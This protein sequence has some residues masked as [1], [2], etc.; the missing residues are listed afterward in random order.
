MTYSDLG[1]TTKKLLF[2]NPFF[3][4]LFIKLS[5]VIVGDEHI[6]DT[7]AVAI[8]ELDGTIR[9]MVYDKFFDGLSSEHRLGLIHHE[10]LH[11]ALLHLSI[12]PMMPNKQLA[13]IAMDLEVNQYIPEENLPDGGLLLSTPGIAELNLPERAGAI[14]YYELL[15]KHQEEKDEDEDGDGDGNGSGNGEGDGEEDGDGNGD[16]NGKGKRMSSLDPGD[17]A[18]SDLTEAD[19]KLIVAQIN[20]HLKDSYTQAQETEAGRKSIGTLPG[21]LQKHIAR[22]FTPDPPVFDWKRYFRRYASTAV[23]RT[24]KKNNKRSS[25]RFVDMPGLKSKRRL[26][27]FVSVDVSGSMSK[28]DISEVFT[29]LQHLWKA[30]AKITVVTWDTVIHETFEYNGKFPLSLNGGGGSDVGIAIKEYNKNMFSY[31]FA[32][33]LTDGYVNNSEPLFGKHLFIITKAGR[34]FN[35][36]GKYTMIQIP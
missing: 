26:N 14:K 17:H 20:E 4:H 33:H 18:F 8:N 21:H 7:A 19:S 2:S 12:A 23:T 1:T 3:G 29:Q 34:T 10:L 16:G 32:I 22:I 35:P 30:G 27:I 13:N 36:G 6:V 5:K 15:S 28:G 31:A 24:K 11:V 25:N 9:L